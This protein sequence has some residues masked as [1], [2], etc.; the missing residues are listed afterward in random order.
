MRFILDTANLNEPRLAAAWGVVDGVTANPKLTAREGRPTA[1][2]VR[3]IRGI[4]DSGFEQFPK[5]YGRAF[6]SGACA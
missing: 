6:P 2:P 3:A 4:T 1:E 5:D